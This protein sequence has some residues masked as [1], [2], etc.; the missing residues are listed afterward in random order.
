MI[1]DNFKYIFQFHIFRFSKSTGKAIS[2]RMHKYKAPK[3]LY[4]D[5]KYILDKHLKHLARVAKHTNYQYLTYNIHY[6][7]LKRH[8]FIEKVLL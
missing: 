8:I 3:R 2:R 5:P 6:L 4:K 1:S 7:I